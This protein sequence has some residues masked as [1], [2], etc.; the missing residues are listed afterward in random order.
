MSIF[1]HRCRYL[2]ESVN[3][4]LDLNEISLD[5]ARSSGFHAALCRKIKN[6]TESGG[7]QWIS[8]SSLSENLWISPDFVDFMVGSGGSGFWGGNLPGDPKGSGPV[9]GNSPETIGLIGS[10]GGRSVSGRSG[11]LSGSPGCLNTPNLFYETCR[12]VW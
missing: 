4:G 7:L 1:R 6:I 11:G 9:G 3:S 10:G 5:L 2:A 12:A 8:R